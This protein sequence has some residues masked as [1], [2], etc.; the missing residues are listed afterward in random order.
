MQLTP[1]TK[2]LMLPVL[3]DG[4]FLFSPIFV[5][6]NLFYSIKIKKNVSYKTHTHISVMIA[7][8]MMIDAVNETLFL[9]LSVFGP[10]Q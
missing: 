10:L 5:A 9:F 7:S 6:R 3:S 8:H 1:V 4:L 2:K